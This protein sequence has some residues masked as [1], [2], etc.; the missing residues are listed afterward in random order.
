MVTERHKLLHHHFSLQLQSRVSTKKSTK[1][2][3]FQ[4][5]QL[6]KETKFGP[7]PFHSQPR[8]SD[9]AKSMQ[10]DT[11]F[12]TFQ[13]MHSMTPSER[14]KIW[15]I[16]GSIFPFSIFIPFTPHSQYQVNL[17]FFQNH[18]LTFHKMH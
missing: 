4:H 18:L 8:P 7:H 11:N 9:L 5:F 16:K 3:K 6:P 14:H 1:P 2:T 12:S 10:K 15:N 17:A 13:K